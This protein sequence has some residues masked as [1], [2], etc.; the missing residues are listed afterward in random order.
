MWLDGT[1][2][3]EKYSGRGSKIAIFV[4]GKVFQIFLIAIYN[5]GIIIIF[6]VKVGY[7]QSAT[8]QEFVEAYMAFTFGHGQMVM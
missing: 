4:P 8:Q 2:I 1:P 3:R 5:K 7:S 6:E